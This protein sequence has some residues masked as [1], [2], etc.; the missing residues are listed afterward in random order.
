M[1]IFY[2]E[3]FFSVHAENKEGNFL[4]MPASRR[5][6]RSRR[7]RLG[8]GVK[9]VAAVFCPPTFVVLRPSLV[10]CLLSPSH[11][12]F[13]LLRASGCVLPTPQRPTPNTQQPPPK[14]KGGIHPSPSTR[15]FPHNDAA[16]SAAWEAGGIF[17]NFHILSNHPQSVDC[18]KYTYIHTYIKKGKSCGGEPERRESGAREE[19]AN[20]EIG[21]SRQ[22]ERRRCRFCSSALLLLFSITLAKGV[23][24]LCYYFR[25]DLGSSN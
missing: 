24:L 8:Y 19:R 2:N 13:P 3:T 7:R 18:R 23:E 17:N 9:T 15:V 25:I 1:T 12:P 4:K 14:S 21:Q 6:S 10:V 5:S 11:L 20:G 22:R 16:P